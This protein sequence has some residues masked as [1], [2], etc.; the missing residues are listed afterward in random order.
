MSN[1]EQI[2]QA[3]GNIQTPAISKHYA[4]TKYVMTWHNYPKDAF[5]QIELKLCPLC[6]LYVFGEEY[7]KS[8][9][10]KH[11][12]G[13][14]ILK[15]NKMRATA[16]QNLFGVKF[17]LAGMKGTFEQQNYCVKEG[18]F[19]LTNHIFKKPKRVKNFLKDEQLNAWELKIVN[20]CDNVIP[21]DRDIYWFWSRAGNLGKTTF[22]KYLHNKYD[23]CVIGGKSA[24]SKN[25]IASYIENSTDKRAPEIVICPIPR[26]YGKE[27]ISYEAIEM[28][29]DMFF[30]SGKYEGGQVNDNPPHLFVF[31]NHTP[32]WSRMSGDRWKVFEIIDNK[33][34]YEETPIGYEY[35]SSESDEED[36]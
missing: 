8:G 15:G 21:N 33:G 3:G 2:E 35:E 32:D 1:V 27:F 36:Y 9:K 4:N 24:D 26:S 5:E 18:N 10:T 13:A 17:Y 22:A 7:G 19:I 11:I 12:Q 23:A 30:Y 29:K 28:I 6:K 16:I 20:L 31:G 25:C 14:F 34:N